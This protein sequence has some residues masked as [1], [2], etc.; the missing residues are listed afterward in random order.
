MPLLAE[1][2][3]N[4]IHIKMDG[5]MLFNDTSAQFRLYILRKYNKDSHII[6]I[7]KRIVIRYDTEKD[8]MTHMQS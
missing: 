3:K 8:I 6:F 7:M 1:S 4:A 5:W 2:I